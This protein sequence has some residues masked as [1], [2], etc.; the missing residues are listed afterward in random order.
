MAKVLAKRDR[1]ILLRIGPST[2][3]RSLMPSKRR[4]EQADW[5]GERS[6]RLPATIGPA[7]EQVPVGRP[8]GQETKT[9]LG[10]RRQVWPM[11]SRTA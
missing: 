6:A 7:E 3:R 1:M 9:A 10:V 4:R 8:A 11:F 5:C 2:G